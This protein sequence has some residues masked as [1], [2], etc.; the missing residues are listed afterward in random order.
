MQ[1]NKTNTVNLRAKARWGIVGIFGL[2]VISA[3]I[4]APQPVNKGIDW[5]NRKTGFGIPE[6]KVLPFRLGLD[7]RG[8]VQLTYKADTSNI[9]Q[10]KQGDAVEGVRDVIERRVNGMG[11]GEATVQTSQIENTYR[12]NVELPGVTDVN[13][14]IKMIGETPTLEFKE[15]APEQPKTLTDEQKKQLASDNVDAKK[16][17][18]DLLSRS[19]KGEAFATLVTSSEDSKTKDNGGSMGLVGDQIPYKELY[20]WATTHKEGDVSKTL[21]ESPEGY[22]ILKLGKEQTGETEVSAS[23]ILVC[24]LGASSCSS[25]MTKQEALAKAEELIKQANGKNF[26]QL[27]KDNST[28]AGSKDKSGDLGYFHKGQMVPEFEKAAFEA[29]KGTIVGPVETQFGYHIIYKRDQ[30]PI[31][32]FELARILVR[33]KTEADILPPQSEWKTTG[34]SGKQLQRAEVVSD[35]RTG[36]VQ[37]SLQ[38]DAD[39]AKLFRDLTER[40]IQKPIAIF[41]DGE[42]ISVPNVNTVIPDGRA[43]ITGSFTI[44][45]AR[46][47]AQR[48]NA[49]AL[50]VPV[51]LISQEGID[52][53]LGQASLHKSLVAGAVGAA[54]VML[55]MIIVYRLP[56]LVSVVSL[57]LYIALSTAIFKVLGITITLAGIAGFIMS[58][59]VAVDANVLIFERM[60]EELRAGKSL[61]NAVEEGFLR[62][63]TSIRDGNMSTLITCVILI[64]FGTSFV[65][66]FAI[67]LA[68]GVLVSLFTAI[69]I[70]RVFLRFITPWFKSFTGG[71]LF[72]A[73]RHVPEEKKDIK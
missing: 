62:A 57:I 68:L 66:G 53:P 26:A 61:K 22:N 14:A 8:G 41:L 31:R 65:K 20:A 11:V 17:A 49:G 24:Y 27:A 9:D 60:K 34:L 67:T 15:K 45:E 39:G 21:V 6:I 58:L 28:D 73:P 52:A 4:A 50:P 7:L 36:A 43:V 29:E 30:R 38:F 64:W 59:G 13:Q 16:R 48:L 63:W 55:F 51:E 70:T 69:T 2:L 47:L 12:I 37:V 10:T 32:Q 18:V 33:T 1:T 3:A 56:G 71:W 25:K 5:L 23:H 44:Q 54:L 42:A 40:N 46:L 72:L 35:S 19:N